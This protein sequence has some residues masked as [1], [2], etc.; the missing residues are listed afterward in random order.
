QREVELVHHLEQLADER[1]GGQVDRARLLAQHAL[2]VVVEF[3]L[4]PLQVVEIFGRLRLRLSEGAPAGG[5]DVALRGG[6]FAPSTRAAR[7]R[8]PAPVALTAF[9]WCRL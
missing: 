7:G 2:A 9:R 4:E 3:R 5:G 6:R 1:L 8:A